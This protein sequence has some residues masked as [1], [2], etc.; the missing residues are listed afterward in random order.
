MCYTNIICNYYKLPIVSAVNK[1]KY[2]LNVYVLITN[3]QI[4]ILLH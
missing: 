2:L 3:K 4:S 1:L